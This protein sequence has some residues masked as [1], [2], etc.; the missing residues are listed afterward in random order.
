MSSVV[1]P[2]VRELISVERLREQRS[3]DEPKLVAPMLGLLNLFFLAY[4]ERYLT[5]ERSAET[6]ALLIFLEITLFVILAVTRYL[7]VTG[8]TLRRAA[9]FPTTAWDRFIFSGISNL[10]RPVSL[11]WWGSVV[12][13]FLILAHGSWAEVFL[14]TLLFSLLV[15][16]AQMVV[17]LLLLTARKGEGSGGA[18]VWALLAFVSGIAVVSLLFGERSL[19]RVLLPV[20]WVAEAIHATGVGN[21][22][23]SLH[24]FGLLSGL[25]GG[26]L[27]LARRIC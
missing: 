5:G 17:S 23:P 6:L 7:S 16:C 12:L 20:Q 18:I 13:A 26:T 14:P 19:L 25:G 9:L 8:E 11:L 10:R 15:L 22:R 4:F 3:A 21:L 27:L 2:V 24:A 1:L